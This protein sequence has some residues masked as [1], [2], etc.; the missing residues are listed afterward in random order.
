MLTSQERL[1]VA[2]AVLK[3]PCRLVSD[4]IAACGP[5]PDQYHYRWAPDYKITQKD[6]LTRK[7]A[8]L[9]KGRD[10]EDSKYCSACRL[11]RLIA[12]DD[13]DGLELFCYELISGAAV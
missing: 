12:E 4:Y 9:I 11:A 6:A 7:C 2:E 3:K 5:R 8:R 10:K 13:V 1:V